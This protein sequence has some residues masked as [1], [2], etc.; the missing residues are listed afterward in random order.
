MSRKF[1]PLRWVQPILLG[2]VMLAASAS[3]SMAQAPNGSYECSFFNSSRAGMNFNLSGGS[4][5]DSEGS[6]GTVSISGNDFTFQGAGLDRTRARFRGGNP[7]T[8]S[9]LGPRG[10]EVSVC[11]LAR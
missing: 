2:G 4:Y 11:Q 10:D 9:M 3:V 5:T 6:K 1:A 7:P 8:F